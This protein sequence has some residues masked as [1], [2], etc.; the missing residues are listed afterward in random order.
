M[1]S[2]DTKYQY[3]RAYVS[4][5]AQ[6]NN[7]PSWLSELRVKGAEAVETLPLPK[8]EKTK[9]D[10][11]NFTQFKHDIKGSTVNALADLPEYLQAMIGEETADTNV[12]VHRDTTLSYS[13]LSSELKEKGVIFTD[14]QTAIRD[15]NELV[16]KFYMNDGVKVDEDKVTAL[17]AA[18]MNGG[19]FLYVP[20]NVVVEL[21]LQ[22]IYSV[23]TAEAGLFNHVLV[24]A[25]ANS[26]VTYIENYTSNTD[27]PVVANI[28]AEVFAGDN[29]R[30]LFGA[31][32]T[33]GKN[34]TATIS[35]R[36]IVARDGKI[37]WAM[38][39]MNDGNTISNNTIHL[40]GDGSQTETKTVTVGRGEQK[41][42]FT[43]QV[44]HYGKNSDSNILNHG[45]M[46]DS[47][48]AIYNGVTKIEH[49]AQK[50]NG[51]QTQRVLMLSEKAR[52][53]ANPILLIDEDDVTAGHAASV[54]KVDALQ[55]YYLMSR[56][57]S[58]ADAERLIIHGFLAPVVEE[59]AIDSVKERLVEVIERKVK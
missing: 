44:F 47:A 31:V 6:K 26:S 20:K 54:G 2:L 41:Q 3:D 5:L 50:A 12:L 11:W 17:H 4:E 24:V 32:D 16:Q 57:I 40:K 1:M 15:H 21:P 29:A 56:G 59:L 37:D 36:G 9:I 43:S 19:T 52:G 23:E 10:S 8:P 45:V 46:R 53:D 28:V 33:F 14:M 48:S 25:E 38:G 27:E 22:A 58:R 18:L 39:Q 55:L 34:V 42:N 49:G 13:K 51:E 30:I 7:E 35:R